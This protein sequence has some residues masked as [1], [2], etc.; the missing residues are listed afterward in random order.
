MTGW[1]SRKGGA[2][3]LFAAALPMAKRNQVSKRHFSSPGDPL[4][5]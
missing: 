2:G 1:G 3:D 4:L 5:L